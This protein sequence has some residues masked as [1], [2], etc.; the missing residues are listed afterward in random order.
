MFQLWK[1]FQV[2]FH[3]DVS[4]VVEQPPKTKLD[5]TTKKL[6]I[7]MN[8]YLKRS[9]DVEC[10]TETQ[11]LNDRKL[12]KEDRSVGSIKGSIF[13]RESNSDTL[14]TRQHLDSVK[15]R[16][17]A[18]AEESR[19]SS[20]AES[21]SSKSV[22]V[23]LAVKFNRASA[24]FELPEWPDEDEPVRVSLD[25]QDTDVS[26]K[27]NCDGPPPEC[28]ESTSHVNKNAVAS[29]P[30]RETRGVE[31]END[32][33]TEGIDLSDTQYRQPYDSQ[34]SWL[35]AYREKH[36]KKE[37]SLLDQLVDSLPDQESSTKES[38]VLESNMMHRPLVK[39]ETESVEVTN[40]AIARPLSSNESSSDF[41]QG[42]SLLDIVID[43]RKAETGTPR[44][45]SGMKRFMDDSKSD[46]SESVVPWANIKLRSAPKPEVKPTQQDVTKNTEVV[47]WSSVVERIDVAHH[48]PSQ[49]GSSLPQPDVEEE[50][51]PWTPVKL[52]SVATHQDATADTKDKRESPGFRRQLRKVP[53]E[54]NA[55]KLK[56]KEMTKVPD[57]KSLAD[58]SWAPVQTQAHFPQSRKIVVYGI[59][60]GDEVNLSS[61]PVEAFGSQNDA[62][63]LDLDRMPG[64]PE[65]HKISV[66]I[67]K[68]MLLTARSTNCGLLSRVTWCVARSDVKSLTLE[69]AERRAD[70]SLALGTSKSIVFDS[71]EGCLRF[72]NAFYETISQRRI[73]EEEER[74]PEPGEAKIESAP[75][76]QITA[77][78]DR[79][80]EDEQ[81]LLRAYRLQRRTKAPEDAMREAFAD[82]GYSPRAV[83]PKSI[84][85]V[86]LNSD[87]EKIASSYR[88][89]LKFQVDPEAVRHKMTKDG[90]SDAIIASVLGGVTK[91]TKP[92]KEGLSDEEEKIAETYRKMLRVSIPPEAVRHKMTKEQVDSRIVDAV[93]GGSSQ[94]SEINQNPKPVLSEEENALVVSYQKMLK[95]M[96]PPEAVRHKMKK[97]QASQNV[98][99]VVF[100]PQAGD[101]GDIHAKKEVALSEEDEAVASSYRKMLK[102]MIPPEAVRHKMEK[103]QVDAKIVRAVL[104]PDPNEKKGRPPNKSLSDADEQ[105]AETYRKMLN[106]KV[107]RDCVRQKMIKN[108]VNEKII[109]VVLGAQHN[110]PKTKTNAKKPTVIANKLVSLHWTPLSG[111]ALD[112][113]VWRTSK[114]R[115]VLVAQPGRNDISQLV[116]LFQK[117]TNNRKPT[118]ADSVNSG[119][120]GNDMAKLLDLN[121]ANNLAISLKTFKDFSHEDL[122]DT[123]AHLDPLRKIT[124]ERLQFMKDLLPT[125]TE[126]KTI[127]EYSGD[128]SRLIPAE[129]FFTKLVKVQ[130]LQTKVQVI[131]T[132]DTL[133][134]NASELGQNFVVLERVCSQ[135]MNSEK[136]EQVLDMVLQIGNI[137]NEGTQTGGAAGFKFDSLL[138][139]T[140]TKSSDG[141]MTVLDYIVMIFVA[142]EKRETLQLTSDFPDC[143]VA[144][145][146]LITDMVN[147]VNTMKNAL[148]KC[149]SELENLRKDS[150]QPVDNGSA[151]PRAGLLAAIKKVGLSSKETG[152]PKR[153]SKRD[154]FLSTIE[155]AKPPVPENVDDKLDDK[156]EKESLVKTAFVA[157]D[158]SLK[159]GMQRL[160][161]FITDAKN[162][163]KNL[164][165]ERDRAIDAC[166]S[167]SR[168]CGESGGERATSALIGIL[169]AFATNLENAVQKHDVRKEAEQRREAAAQKKKE[170]Q[171][172]KLESQ[173]S[174]EKEV[175]NVKPVTKGQSLVLMVNELLKETSDEAKEDFRNGIVYE[176]PDDK[177]KA[178]YQRERESLGIFVPPDARKPSQVDL[179]IAIKKRRER[180]EARKGEASD[181]T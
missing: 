8:L 102:M 25:S 15:R 131:Q 29:D 50:R 3:D 159:S 71:T 92:S 104:G 12:A 61:L 124:G 49:S 81:Q 93:L 171:G 117:K 136:L 99:V 100:G 41:T 14:S 98:I 105:I 70:L 51:P 118:C 13:A 20:M 130:R 82:K 143:Q 140:Q 21:A 6:L 78:D 113:S 111:E 97:D 96:I 47:P 44:F 43:E 155:A 160:E 40:K 179:L 36:A 34:K 72:A 30:S 68:N 177:L 154:A 7:E 62:T 165:E 46:V 139:L 101:S 59:S 129:K 174:K 65:D 66:V 126:V 58:I 121:R 127:K 162:V 109:A 153:F 91:E 60:V 128:D 77:P 157:K 168:Y 169:S 134:D 23:D 18:N 110:M 138:K 37:S 2:L 156:L 141:K 48:C 83:D 56:T 16:L 167:L 180:A 86:E 176:D 89:M 28:G 107:P 150:G 132:M 119:A 181:S 115:K 53:S 5:A 80:S 24:D 149:E 170:Q 74:D 73:G 164:E 1:G 103:D 166:K 144:S 147:E 52:R 54:L 27:E 120:K 32:F 38:E 142:K 175:K 19:R 90:V 152:T 10:V 112:N 116:E 42:T 55:I 9:C 87:E 11:L 125:P 146:M 135:I 161:A 63:L 178:I 67:G 57:T 79:L 88:Q 64:M 35:R 145:R 122:A 17:L 33:K 151:D 94:K 85:G 108:G 75:D 26:N 84:V 69:M 114:K 45:V 137:M 95:M 39:K 158:G 173:P 22:S 76:P 123:I 31:A 148:K 163:L 133:N 172:A 4:P 106:M